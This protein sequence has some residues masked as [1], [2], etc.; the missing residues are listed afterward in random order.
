MTKRIHDEFRKL[1]DRL[2]AASASGTF[3]NLSNLTD[4][5]YRARLRAMRTDD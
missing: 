4:D 3:I 1:R 5:E 2:N